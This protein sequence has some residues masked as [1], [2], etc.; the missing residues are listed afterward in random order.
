[1][2]VDAQSFPAQALW[3]ALMMLAA[4]PFWV[5]LNRW[6]DPPEISKIK[7]RRRMA[8]LLAGYIALGVVLAFVVA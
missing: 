2:L 1:M 3:Q 4:I 6:A 5:L 8:I 7:G